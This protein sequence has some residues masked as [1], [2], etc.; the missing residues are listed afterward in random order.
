MVLPGND[1]EEF[2][3]LHNVKG[4]IREVTKMWQNDNHGS[5]F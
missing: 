5:Y 1:I 3:I 2:E 4:F